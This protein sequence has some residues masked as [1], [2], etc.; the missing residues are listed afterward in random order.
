MLL[1]IL[2]LGA[3][4]GLIGAFA[5]TLFMRTVSA[6]YS[7]RVD[8]LRALGSFFTK[9]AKGSEALGALLHALSG[10]IFG[11]LYLYI[12][13]KMGVLQLPYSLFLGLGFGFFHGLFMSYCLMFV[14]SEHHPL[15]EYKNA[16]LEEG[17]LHLVGHLIFGGVTGF[18][19]G[20]VIALFS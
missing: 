2:I 20:L 9:R 1:P 10:I 12:F 8:M 18:V 6:A 19:G 4:S 13:N 11:A 14:A 15:E 3:L 16:T 7:K 17:L 5:M